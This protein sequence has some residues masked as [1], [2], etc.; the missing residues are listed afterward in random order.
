MV[1]YRKT[2][3]SMVFVVLVMAGFILS[4]YRMDVS[5]TCLP[6]FNHWKS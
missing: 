2:L 3:Y 4:K 5:P 6:I 1:C